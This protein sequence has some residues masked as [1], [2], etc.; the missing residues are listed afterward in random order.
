[1]YILRFLDYEWKGTR[2]RERET[3]GQE[4]DLST[5]LRRFKQSVFKVPKQRTSP[6][7]FTFLVHGVLQVL[8][9]VG[10]AGNAARS[11]NVVVRWSQ[12]K[13]M[14]R[15][16]SRCQ[17]PEENGSF[18]FSPYREIAHFSPLFFLPASLVTRLR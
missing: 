15:T 11:S 14:L 6:I 16:P 3:R 9:D 2:E 5:R 10:T 18:S 7:P 8:A 12:G 13:L 17:D 4:L 1:M